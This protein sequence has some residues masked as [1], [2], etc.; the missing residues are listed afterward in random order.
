[1]GLADFSLDIN[2]IQVLSQLVLALF[3]VFV[4]LQVAPIMSW[5]ERKQMAII[6]RR[7]G[8][9]RVGLFKFRLW[10]LGQPIA[11][12]IKLLYKEDFIPPYVHRFFYLLA[13][14]IPVIM[15]F[16][17]TLSIP[18]GSHVLI[19][20]EHVHL[21][22]LSIS[23]GFLIIFAI[24]ALS[25]YGVV[26]AGWSS[27][28]KYSLLGGLRA[29]AQMISYE[30]AMGMSLIP[31]V[32]IWGTLDL[33]QIVE[34][35]ATTF[36]G[37]VP[38]WGI[39]LAPVSF[40]IFLVTVFAETNR[41]PFDLAESEAELVAGFLTEY[42]SMRWSLFFLGEYAMLFTLSI[43]TISIFLG[44]YELPWLTQDVMLKWMLPHMGEVISRWFLA[45]FGLFV[46]ISKVIL[47]MWF[48]VQVR[49]TIPRFRYDQ[50]MKVGWL[51]LIPIALVN[52]VVTALI[53]AFVKF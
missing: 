48:F 50:L 9:N 24:S 14:I 45:A 22:A 1:M 10:G 8:P 43:L 30:V 27:N 20:G 23:P 49:F 33:S 4:A 11:D 52:L 34:A 37:I 26:L 29:S 42:G 46:L 35:Q 13:P 39:F 25:V 36:F 7:M 5:V 15:G 51:Y 32:F 40:L 28:N 38:A 3:G 6:Q 18:W 19:A 47:M 21:Q 2:W 31:I 12:A 17:V 53:A 41:L 16:A 44:G